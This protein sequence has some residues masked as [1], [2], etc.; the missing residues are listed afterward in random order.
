MRSL[1]LALLLV[2]CISVPAFASSSRIEGR[3]A[4]VSDGDTIQVQIVGGSKVKV[5]FE[6]IDT[7]ET[8]LAGPGGTFTQGYWGNQA[9]NL[10]KSLLPIG[11]QVTVEISGTDDYGRSLG[12][13]FKNGVD[14]NKQMLESGWAVLYEICGEDDCDFDTP[15]AFYEQYRATCETAVSQGVGNFDP[16]RPLP[17]LPFLFRSR[18]QRRPLSKF[19]GNVATRTYL[20]PERYAEIPLCNR[21]FFMEESY[22]VLN[23]FTR[24]N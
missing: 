22:A 2:G 24:A 10:L 7:P 19:V 9:S 4:K 3:V 6:S 13:V 16:A 1:P 21:V 11:T 14:L 20:T 15:G 17:E 5:R 8:T 18:I 23:G 12:R